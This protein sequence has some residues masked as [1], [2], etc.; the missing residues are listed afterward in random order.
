MR[1]LTRYAIVAVTLLVVGS[2]AAENYH[3]LTGVD[4]LRY[5]GA[6]RYIPGQPQGIQPINDG[7]RLAG[8][9]NI[10]PVVSYVGF[11]VPMYQPNRLGSLSFL[12]RRGNL[13]FAGGVPFMGIEFLGGPLLDLDG[14]LNNGQRS[15][16]PVVDVNAVEIPGSD[17]YIRLMPDL[18]AGQIVLADLDITGCNEGA[19]GFGPKIATIIATIAGTQ[20]DG[21]KLPGP[22]PTIDTR[23]GTLTRFA[24]SSGALR[25]VFRI[26]DLGFELWEDS[27]DP[28][29]SSPE[30]LGSMQFFGRLRGWLVLRDRITNTFQPLAG[31]GLGPTGWPS[32]AIGDVGRVVNTANGLAGG[33]ATIL[34][35]FP[36]E[37]Y[38]DPGNG[39][40]P[41]AD[42][43]GDL[44]AYL[45][46]VVLPRLTAG[47]DRFVYLESTGFGVNNSN[48]PI[49]TDTIGYDATIIAAASVCGVQRGGD[50]NCDGVLNFDDIDAFVA[51][52][53]GE[54][55]W[56]ATNPGP[57]CSYKCVND[58]NLDDVV[59]F[60]DIDPFVA[61]LSAP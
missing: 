60:D 26:E 32:V 58:L 29:V 13:P 10:G 46:A 55:S 50:A 21:S 28:D 17:S 11:G 47:Q 44:G 51:A 18:A 37:N 43:G 56:Q 53:S 19:P 42:F 14:D 40:L 6:T 1:C 49:F 20:P 16:I 59:S 36:G 30:V 5:P 57:G 27:L 34:I 25:G 23:V 52:L 41:L 54:A 9:T 38:A 45:D 22:N 35:G 8:T 61:A 24:G 15:L 7:D 39:G 12:W 3:L 33:T 2:A 48:D 31:E 4:A